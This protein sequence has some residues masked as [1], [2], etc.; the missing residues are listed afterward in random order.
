MNGC[1]CVIDGADP[2]MRDDARR[3]KASRRV[4]VEARPVRW[5]LADEVGEHVLQSPCGG[6]PSTHDQ[7]RVGQMT[8]RAFLRER[9]VT[10]QKRL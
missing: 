10:A 6:L 4:A 5:R 9:G 7:R 3:R 2:A 8:L 1:G